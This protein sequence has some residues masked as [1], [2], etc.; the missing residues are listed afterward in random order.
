MATKCE[1]S[2][3]LSAECMGGQG[4]GKRRQGALLSSKLDRPAVD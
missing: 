2:V 1:P 3:S 4:T